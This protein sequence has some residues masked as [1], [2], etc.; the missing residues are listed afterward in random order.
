MVVTETFFSIEVAD[1][2]RATA[3]YAAALGARV[4]YATPVWTSIYIASVRV[5]LFHLPG[6]PGCRTGLHFGV[7]D[8][9]AAIASIEAAGGKLVVPASE[10][11]PGVVVA[12]CIDTE[13]NA[14]AVRQ[15]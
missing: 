4:S 7:D 9:P 14:F 5:G 2:A 15:G 6:H 13:G 11:A 12:D 8:L 10:V 3:F 1:M